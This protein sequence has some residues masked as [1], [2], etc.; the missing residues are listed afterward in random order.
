MK[1]SQK[2]KEVMPNVVIK[3]KFEFIRDRRYIFNVLVKTGLFILCMYLTF[4]YVFGV[5]VM[6]NSDMMP[7]ISAGDLLLYYRLQEDYA[8]P[9]IVVFE[10]DG[11]EYIGRIIAK[12]GESIEITDSHII[13]LNGNSIIEDDIFYTTY[14]YDDYVEY[15]LELGKDEYFI[16]CD[17]REGAKDSRYFGVV[18]GDKIKGCVVSVL[19]RNNL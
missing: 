9:N 1:G 8:S 6:Q 10:L 17:S 5:T 12:S 7:R 16:M 11:E 4:S 2:R 15:P 19:R 3:K 18:T 13:K 14:K